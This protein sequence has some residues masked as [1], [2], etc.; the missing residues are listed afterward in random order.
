LQAI[1]DLHLLERVKQT[2]NYFLN[3]LQTLKS[4][5]VS[6]V[7]GRGLMLAM[8]MPST[9]ERDELVNKL[10]ENMLVLKSGSK[11]IRFRPVLTFNNH[12]VDQAIE[13]LNIALS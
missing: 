6:N 3:Q 4:D 5:K 9:Q 13:F 7:R 1:E 11:S 8:D 10:H 2:G 12:D